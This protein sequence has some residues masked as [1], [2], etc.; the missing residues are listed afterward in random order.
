MERQLEVRRPQHDRY[1]Y[2]DIF[3]NVWVECSTYG[4]VFVHSVSYGL[5]YLSVMFVSVSYCL[6]FLYLES[7]V[8]FLGRGTRNGFDLGPLLC[9][10]VHTCHQHVELIL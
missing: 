10:G 5:S 8:I 2:L 4:T 1:V 7:A 6:D 9:T 3:Q